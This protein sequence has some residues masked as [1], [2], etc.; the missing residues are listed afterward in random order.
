MQI[1]QEMR[2]TGNPSLEINIS[3]S[4]ETALYRGRARSNSLKVIDQGRAKSSSFAKYRA[5]PTTAG[6]PRIKLLP[7]IDETQDD[8]V[9]RN[10]S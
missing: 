4:L 6:N 3:L 10:C 1:G 2:W 9:H 7:K 8:L 5:M